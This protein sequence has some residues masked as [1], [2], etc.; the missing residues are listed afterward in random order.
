MSDVK[1]VAQFG[2]RSCLQIAF[3][4]GRGAGRGGVWPAGTS[5]FSEEMVDDS[6]VMWAG[7]EGR[8][9]EGRSPSIF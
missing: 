6:E 3:S 1:V 8:G 2:P 4:M 7:R 5:Q 9:E